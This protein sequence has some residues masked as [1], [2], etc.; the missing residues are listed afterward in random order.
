MVSYLKSLVV[1]FPLIIGLI[2]L[3]KIDR[4]YQLFVFLM[5]MYLVNETISLICKKVFATNAINFNLFSLVEGLFINYMFYTWG[6]LKNQKKAF[7]FLQLG[8]TLLWVI[9]N[10]VFLRITEFP[11]YYRLVYSF[12]IVLLSVNQIN[13]LIIHDSRNLLKNAQFLI[14][15]AFIIFFMYQILYEIAY[16]YKDASSDSLAFSRKVSRLFVDMNIFINLLFGVAAYFIPKKEKF[17]FTF[18]QD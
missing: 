12:I 4:G 15:I 7:L 18:K 10:L 2:Q 1:L 11:P 8:I 3:R 6:F 9:E 16:Q 5:L 13:Y 17:S 14:C